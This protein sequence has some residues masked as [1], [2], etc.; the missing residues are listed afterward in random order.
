MGRLAVRRMGSGVAGL[1][2]G[3]QSCGA[4]DGQAGGRNRVPRSFVGFMNAYLLSGGDDRYLEVWRKQADRINEQRKMVNGVASTPRMYGDQGWYSYE[5]GDYNLNFLE[6]YFLSMR[7]RTISA[8]A[9]KTPW[10][11]FLEGK[12]ADY[13]VKALHAALTHIRKSV[14]SIRADHDDAGDAAG[15][16]GDG[17]QSGE[18]DGV[19]AVDGGW[20]VYPALG[21]GEDFSG[22]GWVLVASA[23]CGISIRRR[24]A[25][26]CRRM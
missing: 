4:D 20:A 9:E 18:R 19:D 5:R 7:L 12:N 3:V 16:Y 21:V 23:G 15:G 24:G 26:G 1:W 10:Y 11:G 17:L 13:P 22:A 2:V 25:R 14:E 6:I 8:R